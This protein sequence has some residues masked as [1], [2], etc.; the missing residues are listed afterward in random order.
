MLRTGSRACIIVILR[1]N[2]L[3][4]YSTTINNGDIY[5]RTRMD[6][7]K[8]IVMCHDKVIS[9]KCPDQ[10]LTAGYLCEVS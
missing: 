9:V 5:G 3:Q 4:K 10:T 8:L 2:H 6:E 7:M 1:L